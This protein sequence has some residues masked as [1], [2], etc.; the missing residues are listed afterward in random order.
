MTLPTSSQ[1]RGKAGL[2]GT[3]PEAHGEAF[4]TEYGAEV[5][6]IA[7]RARQMNRPRLALAFERISEGPDAQWTR[8]ACRAIEYVAATSWTFGS[9]DVWRAIEKSNMS[10]PKNPRAMGVAFRLVEAQGIIEPTG[11]YRPTKR[12]TANGRPI[13]TWRL[14]AF[15]E[16][17]TPL[18]WVGAAWGE[19]E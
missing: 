7:R 15:D 18:D 16:G 5:A 9:D 14:R 8:F 1:P 11:E 17:S 13:R 3:A 12:A 4:R 6:A 2:T 10:P 19:E